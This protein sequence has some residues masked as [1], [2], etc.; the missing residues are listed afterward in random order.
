[1][2]ISR[3]LPKVFEVGQE[4]FWS[5]NHSIA[6]ATMSVAPVSPQGRLIKLAYWGDLHDTD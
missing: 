5:E 3:S 2:L 1:M 6:L 4:L